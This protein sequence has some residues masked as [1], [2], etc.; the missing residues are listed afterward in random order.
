MLQKKRYP[1]IMCALILAPILIEGAYIARYGVNMLNYDEWG[2][3]SYIKAVFTGDGWWTMLLNQHNEHRMVSLRLLLAA[4]TPLTGWNVVVQMYFSLFLQCLTLLGLWLIFRQLSPN[5]S[6][7]FVPIAWLAFCLGQYGNFL[8]GMQIVFYI[9]IATAVWALYLLS[10][11]TLLAYVL[12]LVCAVISSFSINS[13]LFA[14][15]AGLALLV[16]TRSKKPF[17]AGWTL[18]AL[19]TIVLYYDHYVAPNQAPSL[20]FTQPSQSVLFFLANAGASLGAGNLYFSLVIGLGLLVCLAVYLY[21]KLRLRVWP[22]AAESLALSLILFSLLSSA[23]ITYGRLDL[24]VAWALISRYTSITMLGII[25]MYMLIGRGALEETIGPIRS[26][27]THLFNACSWLF[28]IGLIAS[29]LYGNYE[30]KLWQSRGI[31]EDFLL[32]TIDRQPDAAL[33]GMYIDPSV[34]RTG[35]AWLRQNNL[36]AFREPPKVLLRPE[37]GNAKAS[38]EILPSQP[39]TEDF[40]CGIQTLHDVSVAFLTFQRPNNTTVKLTVSRDG[41]LLGA[42][43][44]NTSQIEDNG[45]VTVQLASPLDNCVGANLRVSIESFDGVHDNSVGVWTVQAYYT[46]VFHQNNNQQIQ[47]LGLSLDLQLNALYYG[48][49]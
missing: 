2:W 29:S 22:S 42:R 25:G 5:R 30:I 10:R 48:L 34:V 45:W 26:L 8:Y 31:F 33:V 15:P 36:N 19:V 35:A 1:V 21:G 9:M 11:R 27:S 3:V 17:I 39:V 43:T 47:T 32:R 16:A 7:G 28:V 14:W 44:L 23:A 46:G 24:G 38:N 4:L 49:L 41:V 40:V 6:W 20:I 37:T 12:A 18:M 13:G